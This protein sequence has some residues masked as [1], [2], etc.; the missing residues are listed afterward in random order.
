MNAFKKAIKWHVMRT[1]EARLDS[2]SDEEWINFWIVMKRDHCAVISMGSVFEQ[3]EK[4]HLILDEL[5]KKK[6]GGKR[7]SFISFQ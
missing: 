6:N 1:M 5:I 7:H 2:M 4:E 3:N